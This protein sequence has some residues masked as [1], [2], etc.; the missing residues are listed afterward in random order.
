MLYY[1]QLLN[2]GSHLL[3]VVALLLLGGTGPLYRCTAAPR[4]DLRENDE[5]LDYDVPVPL[6][7]IPLGIKIGPALE[8]LGFEEDK[9]GALPWIARHGWLA[10]GDR[11]ISMEGE[12][13]SAVRLDH[14]GGP[15]R[16]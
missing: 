2:D 5:S 4:R 3:V 8:V 9:D 14:C 16:T 13:V 6:E 7:A 11:L 10:V 15:V 1:C 12:D